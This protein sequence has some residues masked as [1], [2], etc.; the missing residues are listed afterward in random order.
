MMHVLRHNVG[1]YCTW[2]LVC[3][4]RYRGSKQIFFLDSVGG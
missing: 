4:H 1:L 2:W 3:V